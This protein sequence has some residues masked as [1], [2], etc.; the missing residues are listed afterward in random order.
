MKSYLLIAD[1]VTL[2]ASYHAN[3]RRQLLIKVVMLI[4]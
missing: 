4:H 1:D 3:K 2:L